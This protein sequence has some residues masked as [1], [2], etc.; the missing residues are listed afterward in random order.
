MQD[1]TND[2]WDKVIAIE[3]AKK[4]TRL[5]RQYAGDILPE[6]NQGEY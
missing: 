4:I 1:T 5:K 3:Q 2:L 6:E